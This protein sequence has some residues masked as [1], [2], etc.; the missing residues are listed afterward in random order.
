CYQHNSGY[1]F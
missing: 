1:S